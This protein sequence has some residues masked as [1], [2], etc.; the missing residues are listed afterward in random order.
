MSLRKLEIPCGSWKTTRSGPMPRDSIR[1]RNLS[2]TSA[3]TT[4][5]IAASE[6]SVRILSLGRHFKTHMPKCR[7]AGSESSKASPSCADTAPARCASSISPVSPSLNRQVWSGP[8]ASPN[9]SACLP[10]DLSR[11][12]PS[13][14]KTSP[15][16]TSWA[17]LTI[18]R[19]NVPTRSGVSQRDGWYCGCHCRSKHSGAG[20]G[21]RSMGAANC[22]RTPQPDRSSVSRAN[23]GLPLT[24]C[25][26]WRD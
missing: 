11:I 20:C 19:F 22:N 13:R 2:G 15:G 4:T 14:V 17:S 26:C 8:V 23:P 1:T 21:S 16:P 6:S 18:D 5:L 3:G 24:R 12:R 25:K 9:R 7:M 10:I